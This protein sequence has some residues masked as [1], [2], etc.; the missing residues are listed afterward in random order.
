[1]DTRAQLLHWAW[2][3][4]ALPIAWATVVMHL[5]TPWT[6]TE[7][8]RHLLV[9]Q[10]LIAS[11]LTFATV[12]YF[13]ADHLPEVVEWI[14]WAI[15]MAFPPVMGWRLWLQIRFARGPDP[16]ARR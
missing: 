11:I 12:R 16:G 1:M 5:R 3:Y 7:L 4:G 14:R 8:G 13:Y 10:T 2:T 15:Y 9:Y 6:Q